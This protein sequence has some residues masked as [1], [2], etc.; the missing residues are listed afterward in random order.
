[1]FYTLAIKTEKSSPVY[2]DGVLTESFS[3]RTYNEGM[4]GDWYYAEPGETLAALPSKLVFIT[5]D[6]GYDFDFRTKFGG[7]IV[8]ERFLSYFK[9]IKTSKW[10]IAEL[11]IVNPK[12]DQVCLK[13]YHFIRQVMQEKESVDIINLERSAINYRNNGDIKNILSLAIREEVK[14]DFFSVFEISLLGY[15]FLSS[16]AAEAIQKEDWKGFELVS[17]DKI[18]TVR[19]A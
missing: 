9:S 15:T 18:G 4:S 5:K 19:H 6:K 1:M 13:K 12:G 7:H 8:S 3:A 14:L 17:T 16:N 10:E 2:L 11:T